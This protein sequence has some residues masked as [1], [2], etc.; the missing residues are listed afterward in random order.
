MNVLLLPNEDEAQRLK[1]IKCGHRRFNPVQDANG[2]W[3]ITLF[4]LNHP[5]FAGEYAVLSQ[6]PIIEWQRPD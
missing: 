4:E 2:N 6:Y 1:N 5:L 3:V